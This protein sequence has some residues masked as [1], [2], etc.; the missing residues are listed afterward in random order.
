MN[1]RK[2]NNSIISS[3]KRNKSVLIVYLPVTNLI[4][5]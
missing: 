5:L 1:E 4:A 2:I 3:N